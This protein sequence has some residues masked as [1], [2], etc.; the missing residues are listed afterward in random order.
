MIVMDGPELNDDEYEEMIKELQTEH[1]K[2]RKR[3]RNQALLK[4]LM[5]KTRRGRRRW[6]EDE[7]PLVSEVVGR[8]PCLGTS[9]MVRSLDCSVF[10]LH[11]C[12]IRS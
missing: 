4:Q 7:R 9:R 3:G 10:F 12:I 5:E 6:I 11:S 1:R 8:V 2:A